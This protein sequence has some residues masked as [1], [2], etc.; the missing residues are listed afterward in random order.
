MKVFEVFVEFS[1]FYVQEIKPG[2]YYMV[3]RV[4]DESV[5]L[6]KLESRTEIQEW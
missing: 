5:L 6:G 3:E 1:W 2:V 4:L